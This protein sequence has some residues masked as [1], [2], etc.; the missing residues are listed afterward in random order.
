MH[1]D[2]SDLPNGIQLIL[3]RELCR[4]M[5]FY[6]AATF[7]ELQDGQ[8]TEF[9]KWVGDEVINYDDDFHRVRLATKRQHEL[10]KAGLVDQANTEWDLFMK[11]E[12][13]GENKRPRKHAT[14]S[15]SREA[16]DLAT[17]FLL[18]HRY[19]EEFPYYDPQ[20]TPQHVI[21][22]IE[23][24]PTSDTLFLVVTRLESYVGT[25]VS[26][27][28]PI[29]ERN[30]VNMY[31]EA[32]QECYKYNNAAT[33]CDS[34]NALEAPKDLDN[35]GHQELNPSGIPQSQQ[36]ENTDHPVEAEEP[37]KP[38]EW[39]FVDE[40]DF[41]DDDY[42]PAPKK[43]KTTKKPQTQAALKLV[44]KALVQKPPTQKGRLRARNKPTP[45][46]SKL[47]HVTR[48][49]DLKTPEPSPTTRCSP[50]ASSST[51]DDFV[52]PIVYVASNATSPGLSFDNDQNGHESLSTAE[53]AVDDDNKPESAQV[54]TVTSEIS[55]EKASKEAIPSSHEERSASCAEDPKDELDDA[56]ASATS[57]KKTADQV[58]P[59]N[60]KAAGDGTKTQV[61][62][63]LDALATAKDEGDTE[64]K[65]DD[66][67]KFSN[68]T[69]GGGEEMK[70]TEFNLSAVADEQNGKTASTEKDCSVTKKGDESNA[71]II[72][73]HGF[74]NTMKTGHQ[75][76][77]DSTTK[78]VAKQGADDGK[79][80]AVSKKRALAELSDDEPVKA[81]KKQRV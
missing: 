77:H 1:V 72:E 60:H 71:S 7:I 40:P 79:D 49:D 68:R 44:T 15:I 76:V 33:N 5:P 29:F 14:F 64:K 56:K 25:D 10:I 18:D 28:N 63:G 52:S 80:S 36:S 12:I 3:I 6:N 9:M 41:D 13:E 39:I 21:D 55:T 75:A 30:L 2:W 67:L 48:S 66:H 16:I 51:A 45:S 53:K 54:N 17:I 8:I 50:A 26:F 38:A 4:E 24:I 59:M 65:P 35:Q 42:E 31:Y 32:A 62:G 70:S 73:K 19:H 27:E 23:A 46:P 74:S 57:I 81:I 43:R 22:E 47:R 78:E 34:G 58:E 11:N 37:S 61:I 20:T 69:N